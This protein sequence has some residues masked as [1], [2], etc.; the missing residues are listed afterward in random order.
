MTPE[1]AEKLFKVFYHMKLMQFA[2][3]IKCYS[4]NKNKFKVAKKNKQQKVVNNG[5][6]SNKLSPKINEFQAKILPPS[7]IKKT[8]KTTGSLIIK[9]WH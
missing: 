6:R 3:N 9:G 8:Q 7:T 5:D 2:F 1:I 4:S